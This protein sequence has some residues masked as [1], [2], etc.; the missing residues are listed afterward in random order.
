M[1]P[2]VSPEEPVHYEGDTET[3][4]QDERAAS[5]WS[6][7]QRSIFGPV[8]E[9]TQSQLRKTDGTQYDNTTYTDE[10]KQ[11]HVSGHTLD[12]ISPS[13]QPHRKDIHTGLPAAIEGNLP[14][15]DPSPNLEV[16]QTTAIMA[17]TEEDQ[18]RPES[19]IELELP[20]E[21]VLPSTALKRGTKYVEESR[22]E[23][24]GEHCD[25]AGPGDGQHDYIWSQPE[26]SCGAKVARR[27][28]SLFHQGPHTCQHH[29]RYS[30]PRQR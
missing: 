7:P 24:S 20:P 8:I 6:P 2:F 9:E 19:D 30:G 21:P 11:I 17:V 5:L 23:G 25:A 13:A 22:S 10:E 26:R 28:P 4:S 14:L 12:C 18:P 16:G 29:Q 15:P 1:P 27:W 3:E